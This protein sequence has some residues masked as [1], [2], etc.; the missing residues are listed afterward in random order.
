MI[1]FTVFY[2]GVLNRFWS[3]FGHRAVGHL[4]SKDRAHA[5][6]LITHA[7][8]KNRALYKDEYSKS[9]QPL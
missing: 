8:L 3:P 6:R 2:Q 7:L 5:Q 4:L 9:S 1:S